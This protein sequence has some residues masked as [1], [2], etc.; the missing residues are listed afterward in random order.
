MNAMRRMST[1]CS[2]ALL[3]ATLVASPALAEKP[4]PVSEKLGERVARG[5]IQESLETLDAPENRERLG[6][7][8]RS[9]QMR[10]ALQDLSASIVMGVFEG[11]RE[12]RTT[13]AP[14]HAG[15]SIRD[16]IDKQVTPAIGRMTY[17]IVDSALSASLA[18]KHVAPIENLAEGVS[19]AV[20]RGVAAGLEQDLGP[21]LARS[22]DEDIGPAVAVMLSRDVLPAVGRGLDTPEMQ[23]AIANISRSIATEFVGGAGD[24]M[25]VQTEE[26]EVQGKQSGLQM[27]GSKVAFGYAIALFVSFALATMLVVLTVVLL[28]SS[29]RQRKQAEAARRRET[30]LLHLVDSLETDYPE[31]KTD[32]RRLLQEQLQTEQ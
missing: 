15:R 6:R 7:I 31:L 27:F 1:W 18:D 16:G 29:R 13:G 3:G 19:R 24:A 2:G 26:N 23:S 9:P 22:I 14:G 28:R 8:L 10:A 11:V 17:R 5:A 30:A 20:V 25:D 21:A 32:M 4:K 12:A